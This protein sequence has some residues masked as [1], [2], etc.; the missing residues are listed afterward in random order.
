MPVFGHHAEGIFE[1]EIMGQPFPNGPTEHA[2]AFGVGRTSDDLTR[3]RI[4][5]LALAR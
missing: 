4:L 5:T 1:M 3:D 2:I